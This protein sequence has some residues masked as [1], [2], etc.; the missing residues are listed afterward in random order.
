VTT[1]RPR[2]PAFPN[3]NYGVA[4]GRA[5]RRGLNSIALIKRSLVA[6]LG[7]QLRHMFW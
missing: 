6:L 4:N 2:P 7:E 1:A 3:T 5:L